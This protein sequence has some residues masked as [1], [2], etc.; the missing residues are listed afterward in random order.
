MKIA[1]VTY[2]V[3]FGGIETFLKRIAHCLVGKG[4]A[5]TI[6]ETEEHGE[7]ADDFSAAGFSVVDI[8]GES[9]RSR[10]HHAKRI[11]SSLRRFDVII[12]NDAPYAQAVLGLLPR[13]TAVFPVV[14]LDMPSFYTNAIGS[15]GEWD[16]VVSV[17]PRVTRILREQY[18]IPTDLIREIPYGVEVPEQW[19]K[20]SITTDTTRPLKVVYVGRLEDR[21]KGVMRL[22][23]IVAQ[24]SRQSPVALE[25]VGDGPDRQKLQ[26]ALLAVC[27]DLAVRFH[28]LLSKDETRTVLKKQD[29]LILPS[30]FEGYPIVVLEAMAEGVVPVVSLLTDTTDRQIKNGETGL[31]VEPTDTK[32]FALALIQLAQD[33]DRLKRISHAAWQEA[34]ERF[35][36]ELMCRQY[37]EL[38]ND[39]HGIRQSGETLRSGH[40]AMELLGDLPNLPLCMVRPV[41]KGLRT[42][43][44]WPKA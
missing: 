21:Q 36:A 20:A 23:A 26:S 7:W 33:R 3:K 41:R 18:G 9:L 31:L 1:L 40:I 14:H 29:V 28:G 39:L 2:A 25:I 30:T 16:A 24:A 6:V 22:P 10:T 8:L 42:L 15:R 5:V 12:L 13:T 11:A 27:P 4:H 19:P 35:T 38:I 37:S 32:E 17:G 43:G 44:L 34:R